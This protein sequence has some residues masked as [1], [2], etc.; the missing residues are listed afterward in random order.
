[1][2]VIQQS[3]H[4]TKIHHIDDLLKGF[5]QTCFESDRNIIDPGVTI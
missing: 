3:L 5:I 4:E 1:M 2:G